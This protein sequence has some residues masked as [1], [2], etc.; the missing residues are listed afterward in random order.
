MANELCICNNGLSNTGLPL[1]VKVQK[2][3]KKFVFVPLVADDGTLNYVNPAST[4]DSSWVQAL[5]NNT[6]KSKRWFPTP[7]IK[8]ID[9]PK[10][11][12][13]YE[14]YNDASSNFIREGVRKFEGLI[15]LC[16]PMYKSKL[17]SVRCNQGN[18]GI[19][20]IDLEGNLVGLTNGSDSYLYPIPINDQSLVANVKFGNDTTTTGIMLTFEFPAYLNDGNIRMIASN[21][22]SD[23]SMLTIKGLL[24]VSYEQVGSSTSTTFTIDISLTDAAI[25]G[26]PIAVEGLVAADFASSVGG[27][28]SKIR[29]TTD[30]ADVAVTVAESATVPGRYTFTYTS[31]TAADDLVV[32]LK[33]NGYDADSFLDQ[34]IEAA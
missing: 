27:A 11:N 13:V 25:I 22:F 23:F 33:K 34:H 8:N 2:V 14:S 3:I 24:D 10:E 31:Q 7:E 28:T 19:Y 9:T 12:P 17:E 32:F 16:P 6:D 29:N 15:P 5:I 18:V 4:L 30:G 26:D 20:L 21:S 1:C